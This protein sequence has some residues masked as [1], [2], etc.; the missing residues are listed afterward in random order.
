[1]KKSGKFAVKVAG[2]LVVVSMFSASAFAAP[3]GRYESSNRDD[4]GRITDRRNNDRATLAGVVTRVDR[5]R[6]EVLI[7]DQRSGRTINVEMRGRAGRQNRSID[8]SDL[9]RGDRV[10][11][12]GQWVNRGEF[13]AYRIDSVN[14]RR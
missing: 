13:E 4:R 12:E 6:G 2:A 5:R 8:F 9:R 11:L 10:V 7:R 3:R 14:A 1:M